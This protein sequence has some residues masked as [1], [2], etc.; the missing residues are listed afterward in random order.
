[1]SEQTFLDAAVEEPIPE[2]KVPQSKEDIRERIKAR[3]ESKKAEQDDNKE[4][5][6]AVRPAMPRAGTIKRGITDIYITLG[7]LA[8]P[9]DPVCGQ[10][11]IE[12]AENAGEALEELA[13]ADPRVRRALLALLQTS[14]WGGVI[15]AHAPIIMA[16]ASHHFVNKRNKDKEEQQNEN[17]TYIP[18]APSTA[19]RR[20]FPYMMPTN[21]TKPQEE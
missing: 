6:F 1:M 3:V 20:G 21:S 2:Q 5:P 16:V 17:E 11:I 12:A 7:A 4:T 8:V 15:A 18:D 14:A 10:A 19:Q 13:K 9:F